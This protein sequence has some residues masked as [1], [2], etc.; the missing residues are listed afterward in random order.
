MKLT[1]SQE[2]HK[3]SVIDRGNYT[4]SPLEDPRVKEEVEAILK[5]K[6]KIEFNVLSLKDL[7]DYECPNYTWRVQNLIQD[8]KIIIVSGSSA[9]YKSWFLLNMGL[10]VAKGIPF[11]DNFAVEQGAVLLIDRENSIPELQNRQEMEA[12]G[13]NIDPKEELPIYFLSEQS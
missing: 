1:E 6:N 8:K 10:C 7:Q 2:A 12:K 3:K 4:P 13:M 11:L 9:V 5:E